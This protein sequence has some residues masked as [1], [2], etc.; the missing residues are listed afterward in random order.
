MLIDY[1][2]GTRS[3]FV[4]IYTSDSRVAQ[5]STAYFSLL[6]TLQSWIRSSL[7]VF[8]PTYA[9]D[10][11]IT[12]LLLYS[13][14]SNCIVLARFSLSQP[15]V[16]RILLSFDIWARILCDI[17]SSILCVLSSLYHPFGCPPF[18]FLFCGWLDRFQYIKRS[19]SLPLKL[20]LNSPALPVVFSYNKCRQE[21]F[22][23]AGNVYVA[24]LLQNQPT[25]KPPW[26]IFSFNDYSVTSSSFIS[27]SAFS[28]AAFISS[29]NVQIFSRVVSCFNASCCLGPRSYPPSTS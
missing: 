5:I 24:H 15:L 22:F 9:H 13:P 12:L 2:L 8:P 28:S 25:K 23:S 27:A 20:F 17:C 10:P 18:D 1:I 3:F 19:S 6:E 11:G 26:T 21:I 4:H 29:M 7:G 16:L 14:V